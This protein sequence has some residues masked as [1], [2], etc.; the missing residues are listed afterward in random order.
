MIG[1]HRSAQIS[2][3]LLLALVA[4]AYRVAF[5]TARRLALEDLRE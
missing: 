3:L 1:M 2:V 5:I 4:I